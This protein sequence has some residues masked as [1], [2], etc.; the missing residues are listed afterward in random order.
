MCGLQTRNPPI[1]AW[2]C[3]AKS[4]LV[5]PPAEHEHRQPKRH[6]GAASSFFRH[7]LTINLQLVQTN[8]R[9]LF[10]DIENGSRL[11][12]DSLKGSPGN[13]RR[14]TVLRE[15]DDH[16]TGIGVPV[17]ISFELIY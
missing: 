9:L 8:S 4:E 3:I 14:G 16:S 7:R 13:V 2:I 1:S 11:V 6:S 17:P 5:T 10:D 15:S 12:A